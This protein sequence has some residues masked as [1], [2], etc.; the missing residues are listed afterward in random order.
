MTST[1]IV[2][3]SK[4]RGHGASKNR[5]TNSLAGTGIQL[6]VGDTIQLEGVAINSVGIANDTI[7]LPKSIGDVEPNKGAIEFMPYLV[8]DGYFG[9]PLPYITSIVEE[10]NVFVPQPQQTNVAI[11]GQKVFGSLTDV[12]GLVKFGAQLNWTRLWYLGEGTLSQKTNARTQDLANVDGYRYYLMDTGGGQSP[13]LYEWKIKTQIANITLPNGYNS[14][15]SIADIVTDSL[16]SINPIHPSFAKYFTN[17][18]SA[19]FYGIEH[20]QVAFTNNTTYQTIRCNPTALSMSGTKEFWCQNTCCRYPFHVAGGHRFL[21]AEIDK[22]SNGTPDV[23]FPVVADTF[24]ETD[25][26]LIT[27]LKYYENVEERMK[28]FFHMTGVYDI[29]KETDKTTKADINNDSERWTSLIDVGRSK[30]PDVAFSPSNFE[31]LMYY[32]EDA[33]NITLQTLV[34]SWY[35]NENIMQMTPLR[36][37]ARYDDTLYASGQLSTEQQN[38]GWY[39]KVAPFST[40][41]PINGKTPEEVAKELNIIVFQI[42]NTKV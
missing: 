32:A 5:W 41:T 27:N 30:L 18:D 42:L 31:S 36:A 21:H 8:N 3:C 28:D 2:E 16:Q 15:S 23:H 12:S 25:T 7:F 13:L 10:Y 26:V 40:D 19:P 9:L 1:I 4:A 14:P 38:N 6:N 33:A 39:I 37:Y 22:S 35:Q 11:S 34:P 29:E 20:D 24:T 17:T